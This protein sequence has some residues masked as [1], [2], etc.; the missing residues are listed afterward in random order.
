MP[1]NTK[2]DW[3]QVTREEIAK[4]YY[5]YAK[6]KGT[7]PCRPVS[8]GVMWSAE[9]AVLTVRPRGHPVGAEDSATAD[10]ARQLMQFGRAETGVFELRANELKALE[11]STTCCFAPTP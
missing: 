8:I 2:I 7:A 1:S 6:G 3:Q 11:Q 10:L 4:V 5:D 9:V